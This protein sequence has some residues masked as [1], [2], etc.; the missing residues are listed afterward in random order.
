MQAEN[1]RRVLKESKLFK[2]ILIFLLA[3]ILGLYF[4]VFFTKGIQ[5]DDTFL[6]KDVIG[7]DSHFIGR[8]QWGGI[9]I[10]VKGIKGAYD[11]YNNIYFMPFHK[12]TPAQLL[13][14]QHLYLH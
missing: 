8:N 14:L 1:I 9:H 10:T 13:Q 12:I 7:A 3:I 5:Y 11:T 4:R 6:K 2:I